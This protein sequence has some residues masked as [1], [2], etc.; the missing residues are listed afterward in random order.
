[1]GKEILVRKGAV[2]DLG[3]LRF[4]LDQLIRRLVDETVVGGREEDPVVR[5]AGMPEVLARAFAESSTYVLARIPS[6]PRRPL[7]RRERQVAC[8]AGAGLP[9]RA[10][11]ERLA[12]TSATVAAHLRRVYT[13]LEVSTRAQLASQVMLL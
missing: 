6:G 5:E 3:D 10:I 8:L 11:A 7:T 13:K 1:M 2:R 12:I 9:N 4:Q